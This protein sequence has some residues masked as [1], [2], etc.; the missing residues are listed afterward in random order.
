MKKCFTLVELLVV[1]AIIGILAGLTLTGFGAARKN[2]RDVTRKSD[3]AQYKASL[4]AYASNN[5]G[6]YPYSTSCGGATCAGNS[7][8][9]G[10]SG[11]FGADAASPLVPEYLPAQIDDP[12]NDATNNY[13]YALGSNAFSYTLSSALET[14]GYWV[15]CASGFA[16]KTTTASCPY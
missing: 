6:A 5:N 14:G 13:V 3:L 12:I 7:F 11:I 4:E 8:T 10:G 16:G 1:I 9:G 2:A 15:L